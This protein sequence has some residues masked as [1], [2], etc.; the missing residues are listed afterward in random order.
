[1]QNYLINAIQMLRPNSEFS[2]TNDDY[3]TIKWDVLDGEAPT[4]AEIDAAI[5]LIK[6]EEKLA[7]ETK[8]AQRQAILDRIGLTADELQ[9]ILG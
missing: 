7:A 9:I 4:Q 5:K 6:K 1:M 3:S 2:F 8:A